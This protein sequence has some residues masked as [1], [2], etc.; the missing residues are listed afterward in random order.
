MIETKS[1]SPQILIF[2]TDKISDPG[3]DLAGQ[4][5]IHYSPGTS[6][7]VVPCSSGI[8]P[9]WILY[10]LRKGF[11]GVFV[12]ADG[13]DCPYLPD[14]S[15]RTGE[16]IGKTQ[17]LMRTESIDPKRLKMAAICSVCADSFANHIS[18]FSKT[19]S[20]LGHHQTNNP[21]N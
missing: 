3:I 17:E 8:K 12:A 11:D 15:E 9:Q 13:T 4:Q 16:I 2:S 5:H 21:S 18:N 7:I 14:C 19:L 20:E 1:N 6:C 10:A